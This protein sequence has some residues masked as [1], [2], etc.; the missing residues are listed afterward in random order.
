MKNVS[1]SEVDLRTILFSGLPHSKVVD[2]KST[3][4]NPTKE[5]YSKEEFTA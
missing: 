4:V 1:L 5:A 3:A 2:Y